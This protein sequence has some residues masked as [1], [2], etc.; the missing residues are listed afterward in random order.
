MA[1]HL[2]SGSTFLSVD[3]K[4]FLNP[5]FY[6]RDDPLT[7]SW[8]RVTSLIVGCFMK[9][10]WKN[11]NDIPNRAYYCVSFIAYMQFTNVAASWSKI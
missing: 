1:Q 9:R 8:Q 5:F 2:E 10:M 3:L 7:V 11:N 6:L 4:L